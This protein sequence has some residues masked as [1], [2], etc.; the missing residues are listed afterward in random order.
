[1][2]QTKNIVVI[3]II[4]LC[5]NTR[6]IVLLVSVNNALEK[7][8]FKFNKRL[9]PPYT[10]TQFYW[11]LNTLHVLDRK[12]STSELT[13]TIPDAKQR[14]S[15]VSKAMFKTPTW[16]QDPRFPIRVTYMPLGLKTT[17]RIWTLQILLLYTR[18]KQRRYCRSRQDLRILSASILGW[19][20]ILVV[21][22]FL[23]FVK[24][25][26]LF[27]LA[28]AQLFSFCVLCWEALSIQK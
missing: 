18:Q 14:C 7:N 1:M 12:S 15:P 2:E 10:H 24:F 23:S 4:S 19:L 17:T 5:S 16:K 3:S 8:Q 9:P 25:A 13:T 6:V 22:L 20:E 21:Q 11:W 27:G 26:K 28:L